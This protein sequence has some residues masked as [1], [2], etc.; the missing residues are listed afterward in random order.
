MDGKDVVVVRFRAGAMCLRVCQ[1]SPWC[2]FKV[3]T[4]CFGFT[5]EPERSAEVYDAIY[6][7]RHHRSCKGHTTPSP[8]AA[9]YGHACP[10]CFSL[11]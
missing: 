11:K 3:L 10:P 7:S 4:G 8:V 2:C 1:R 6:L 5:R 9:I